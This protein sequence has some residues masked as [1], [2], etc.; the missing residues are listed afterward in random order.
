LSC[1]LTESQISASTPVQSRLGTRVH[2]C[3]A[4]GR[5]VNK[6]VLLAG[7]VIALVA[8]AN[9]SVSSL[10]AVDASF[11][12]LVGPVDAPA[13]PDASVVELVAPRTTSFLA[14]GLPAA[15]PTLPEASGAVSDVPGSVLLSYDGLDSTDYSL[16]DCSALMNWSLTES[17]A[18]LVRP[19]FFPDGLF[20][21][22][23]ETAASS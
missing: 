16:M 18:P 20:K 1:S 8:P 6:P 4:A 10:M 9:P 13:L 7:G 15:A 11:P 3:S 5:P 17:A 14:E 2:L 12:T 21:K 19:V 22:G 23:P